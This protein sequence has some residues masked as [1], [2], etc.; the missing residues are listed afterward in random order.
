MSDFIKK[1]KSYCDSN[2]L[3]KPHDTIIVGL[4]GGPD[5]IFLLHALSTLAPDYHLTLIAAHL[6]HEWRESSK[7]DAQIAHL[8]ALSLG[9]TYVSQTASQISLTKKISGSKEDHARLLRRQFFQDLKQ[10]H[11]AQSIALAH[12]Q[13]DMI[14]TFFI[15]LLRGA[16]LSGLSSIRVRAGSY[17]RPLLEISKEEILAYLHMHNI[18]YALDPTNESDAY[19]RNRIRK[20]IIPSCSKSDERFAINAL[21]TIAHLQEAEA[22]IER[23]TL[24]SLESILL[25]QESQY[26]L[27][28][29]LF[30]QLDPFMQHRVLIHWLILNNVPFI[31][32]KKLFGEIIRFIKRPGTAMHTFYQ[33]WN[34]R[35]T[36][37]KLVIV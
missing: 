36:N 1:I 19:L 5:S 27:D 23:Q 13:D 6:D 4:S 14:E 24:V 10:T 20:L 22:Y 18:A 30:L 17:I 15:R 35:K 11:N 9:I 16:G 32:S 34:I 7:I 37:T 12:H 3:L 8:A 21:K 33:K 26:T 2:Q 29:I 31:P 28:R 25:D